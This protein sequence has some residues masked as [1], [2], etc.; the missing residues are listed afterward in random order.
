VVGHIAEWERLALI[1]FGEII[2]GMQW[3]RMMS[4][5]GYVES[6][7][8]GR[9]FTSVDAFDAAVEHARDLSAAGHSDLT[10]SRS[11]SRKGDLHK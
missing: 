4:L 6:D 7:G 3:P 5:S 10:N 1:A 11:K 9:A 8:Q 2:A